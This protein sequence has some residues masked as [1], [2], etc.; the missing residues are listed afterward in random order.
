VI[1]LNSIYAGAAV[2]ATLSILTGAQIMIVSWLLR[3]LCRDLNL[4]RAYKGFVKFKRWAYAILFTTAVG[5]IITTVVIVTYF[6][7]HSL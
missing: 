7:A 2:V 3:T 1:A 4:P 6:Q 5:S